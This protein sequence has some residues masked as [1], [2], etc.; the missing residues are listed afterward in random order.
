M[1]TTL[2]LATTLLLTGCYTELQ[3]VEPYRPPVRQIVYEREVAK[4]EPQSYEEEV[5]PEEDT[6]TYEEEVLYLRDRSR[7]LNPDQAYRRGFADGY[8]DGYDDARYDIRRH[9]WYYSGYDPYFYEP[10]WMVY[11]NHHHGWNWGWGHPHF[12]YFGYY[13]GYYYHPFNG[14]G[15]HWVTYNYFYVNPTAETP[16]ARNV[17]RGR[18]D[19]GYQGTSGSSN[20]GRVT[21]SGTG[22]RR[23]SATS[24]GTRTTGTRTAET[25][26]RREAGSSS[27]AGTRTTSSGTG[28]RRSTGSGSTEG[29]RTTGSGTTTR[30]RRDNDSPQ[31]NARPATEPRRTTEARPEEKSRTETRTEPRRTTEARP[32]REVTRSEAPKRNSGSSGG[33]SNS[34]ERPK[35]RN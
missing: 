24:D 8:S 3:V 7:A 6:A 26:V 19:S 12:S 11:F 9:R 28:V 33:S 21:N 23:N 18:R 32:Q 10:R 16:V 27:N 34:T 2:S 15:H 17:N 31:S 5:N 1:K 4:S 14:F 35:R 20:T 25:Q 22:V 13:P 29:T 30:P